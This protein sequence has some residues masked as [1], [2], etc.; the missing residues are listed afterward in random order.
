MLKGEGGVL[1]VQGGWGVF[2]LD[3]IRYFSYAGVIASHVFPGVVI[4]PDLTLINPDQS[5]SKRLLQV[6]EDWN[7]MDGNGPGKSP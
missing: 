7:R 6:S 1:K 4:N 3:F 5:Q 2:S